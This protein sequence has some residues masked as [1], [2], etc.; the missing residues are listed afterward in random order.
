MEKVSGG[1]ETSRG[2]V[3]MVLPM[4]P[5][6]KKRLISVDVHR[7]KIHASLYEVDSHGVVYLVAFGERWKKNR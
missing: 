2:F 1:N 5:D 3:A 4:R 7:D 6:G